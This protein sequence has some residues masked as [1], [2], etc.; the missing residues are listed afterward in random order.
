MASFCL[1]K[2]DADRFRKALK[3]G[4]ID[5]AHLI[6]MTSDE[7]REFFKSIVGKENAQD[8]NALFESKLLLKNQQAGLINWARKVGGMTPRIRRNI[9]SRI[10]KMEMVLSA[11]EE[12]TF[13]KD[14]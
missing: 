10:E 5:P 3:D 4:T 9:L 2:N 6:E 1:H 7:R 14:L 8:V 13:L 11:K 12:K